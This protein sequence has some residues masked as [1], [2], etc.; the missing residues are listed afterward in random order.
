MGLFSEEYM[1][2]VLNGR[3]ENYLCDATKKALEILTNNAGK[4]GGFLL[5]VEGSQIDS[6]AHANN[7]QGILAE[8]RDFDRAVGAAMDYA[9]AH[10]GTLVVVTADHETSA[11][12]SRAT[13]PIS[14]CRTAASAIIS[15]RPAIP[16]RWFPSIC[17]GPAPS[18]STA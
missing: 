18:G 9:D 16:V 7:A 11:C 12:R 4:K 10:P 17:T 15:A 2:T 8:T 14:R 3:D 6:E 13:R 5:M 1:P